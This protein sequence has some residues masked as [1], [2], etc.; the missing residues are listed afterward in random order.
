MAGAV[1]MAAVAF[2]VFENAFELA[3]VALIGLLSVAAAA[4]GSAQTSAALW[5]DSRDKS[6]IKTGGLL[7]LPQIPTKSFQCK[8]FPP[9]SCKLCIFF[10]QPV[11][12]FR[13][14][15]RWS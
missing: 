9:H 12:K 14:G 6:W 11:C 15:L 2:V 5:R 4:Q 3:A 10:G 1:F 13:M 8:N 7:S